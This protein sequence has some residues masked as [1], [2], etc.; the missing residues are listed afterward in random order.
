LANQRHTT[1]V[2]NDGLYGDALLNTQTFNFLGPTIDGTRN[3]T[4]HGQAP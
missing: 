4:P 2:I 3:G 1:P